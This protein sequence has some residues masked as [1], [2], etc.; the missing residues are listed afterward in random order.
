[1]KIG[2]IGH[3]GLV[4]SELIKRG[5]EPLW[6]DIRHKDEVSEVIRGYNPDVII[7]CAAITSVDYCEENVKEAKDV[8]VR[9]VSNIVDCFEGRLIQLSTDH[10]FSGK[11]FF[12]DGYRESHNPAPENIYGMT[13]WAGERMAVWGRSDARII[14]TSK[15]FDHDYVYN[16]ICAIDTQGPYEFSN[17]LKRSFLHIEHFVDGLQFVLDNW[18]KMPIILN[19]SGTDVMTHYMFFCF[20]AKKY[21]IDP[22]LVKPR[23]TLL[24]HLTPRPIRGGLNVSKARKLGVPLYSAFDG[25]KLL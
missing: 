24:K 21:G 17:V 2:I 5:Y 10:I 7:N 20:V 14:R 11:K 13:K 1:M 18:E 12:S 25:I 16:K 15:L 22:N 8:N 19:I 6:C 4:G 23:N 9:G 3:Q